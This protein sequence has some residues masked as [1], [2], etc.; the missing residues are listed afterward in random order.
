AGDPRA[1]YAGGAGA[2][3]RAGQRSV[4]DLLFSFH[5]AL[6]A[7]RLYPLENQAVQNAL[8]EL[9]EDAHVI[10]RQEGGLVLR[11]VG[12]FCFVNDLR[13]RVDLASYAT[14][15]AV[16]RALRGHEISQIEADAGATTE[17][18]TALLSLLLQEPDP[19]D[20]FGRFS[21]R[22][23]RSD[24]QHLGVA[25]AS[26]GA[27]PAELEGARDEAKRT[28]AQSVA[29]AREA[30]TGVRMGRAVSVRRVK[31]VVQQIVD[32][33]LN[34]ESSIMGMT[35][36]RDYDQYT[37]AHSVNVCIFSIALGKKLD[38]SKLEL[39]ELGMG[40]LMHDIGKAKMPIEL[41]TKAGILEEA[42]WDVIRE[43]PTEGLM[44][45]L[46]MRGMGEIPFRTMLTAYEHHM[47]IDQT[48]YPPSR[49]S[50]DPTL[51]SRI[52]AVADGFDAATTRR[53]YQ[54]EPWLPDAVLREMRDNPDRGFDQLLVKAFISMTGFY[55][56][57]S[58]V[59]LDSFE[60]A[61]VHAANQAAPHRPVV[62]VIYDDMGI[63]L[64]PPRIVDLSETDPETGEP[65][66]SIIKTTDPEKYGINVK[67]Y[68][69]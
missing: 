10:A 13:L 61:V 67:D 37:F 32:Q 20:P 5:A 23:E 15:G 28:Y 49:R 19:S 25:A 7:L 3:N 18:W 51:F 22:L 16:G 54:A 43:H 39:Y 8:A 21:E 64:M 59:V 57:G 40:A 29:V 56:A 27:A 47:K 2:E 46:E 45:L 24:I 58:L 63:P 53:S 30:L 38:L 48:G 60:I 42:E 65:K 14:F 36:L 55:P 35:V 33:V 6:R 66:R 41:T 44:T 1:A 50:R 68:F 11:Y 62:K 26:D 9:T 4:R 31:R 12:D 69:V 17:E 52:V 34:N